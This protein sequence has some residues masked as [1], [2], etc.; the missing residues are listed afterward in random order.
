DPGH[1][2]NSQPAF[3]IQAFD[4]ATGAPVPCAAQNYVASPAL[5]PLGFKNSSKSTQFDTI[6]YLPWT[7][8]ALPIIG[9]GGK[10]IVIEI[11]TLDC[12]AGGHFGYGYFDVVSC[13]KYKAAVTYCNLDSGLIRF[14]GTGVTQEYNWYTSNWTFIGKGPYIDVVPPNTPD[15][16]YGVLANGQPGC[17]DTIVTD[18]VS[19]FILNAVPAKACVRFGN[20]IQLAANAS[21][22]VGGFTYS[23]DPNPDLSSVTICDPLAMRN[24]TATYF[25][26]VSDRNGGSKG[27]TVE[28]LQP[29][30]AGPDLSVCPLGDRPAQLRV[31]GA[32]SATYTW[33]NGD[34]SSASYLSCNP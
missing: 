29:P 21:G 13:G 25:G 32:A 1:T 27:A 15:Y 19:D 9:Q 2:A 11:T 3:V 18:T 4:S 28:I 26:T 10:T 20:T 16:F 17:L 23:W 12:S 30:D 5:I 8:G 7:G 31:A 24:D 33:Y 6:R 14:I 34:G 22:G